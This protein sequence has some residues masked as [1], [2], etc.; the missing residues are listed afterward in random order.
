MFEA[1]GSYSAG[2]IDEEEVR[3]YEIMLVQHVVH[4]LGCIRLIQ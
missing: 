1:V 4:V 3:Y 2:K